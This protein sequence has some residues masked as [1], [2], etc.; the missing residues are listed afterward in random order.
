[1]SRALTPPLGAMP[2][3]DES[4]VLGRYR[5]LAKLGQGGMSEVLLASAQSARGVVSKLSV[6]KRLRPDLL[7]GVEGPASEGA[8]PHSFVTMFLEE[9]RITCRLNH[10]N[11]VHTYEV[12]EEGGR[13]CIV[14][15]YIDGES[16]HAIWRRLGRLGRPM[17]PTLAA[18][19]MS[20]ALAGLHYAHEL[21]DYDG[22]PL[23]VVHRDVSPHNVMVS[24]QGGVKLL[25]FGIAKASSSQIQT[26]VGVLKGKVHYMAPEQAQSQKVDRRADVFSAGVI[27]WELLTSRRLVQGETPVANWFSLLNDPFPKPSALLE[28]GLDPRLDAVVMR[29]LEKDPARRYPSALAMREALEEYVAAAGGGA[30]VERVGHFVGE[31][32]AEEREGRKRRLREFLRAPEDPLSGAIEAP[33][34]FAEPAPTDGTPSQTAMPLSPTV[35]PGNPSGAPPARAPQPGRRGTLALAAALASIALSGFFAYGRVSP[36]RMSEFGRAAPRFAAG[37]PIATASALLAPAPLSGAVAAPPLSGAVAALPLSGAVAAPPLSGETPRAAAGAAV[38][39][40]ASKPERPEGARRGGAR[41][42]RPALSTPRGAE[43]PAEASAA[44]GFLTLDTYPWSRVSE[45]GR[46]LGTTP[47]VR[48]PLSPGVHT[49]TLEN[50]AEGVKKTTTITIKSGENLSKRLA[51]Q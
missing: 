29:A 1:M 16:L 14:M 7:A 4:L 40:P 49:L 20:E 9:A 26:E 43:P 19:V 50:P 30:S 38:V 23:D 39:A 11:I 48:V 36:P 8:A 35:L 44:N 42:S 31:L 12:G 17:P 41:L 28:G 21:C 33:A 37:L 10:P 47:L 34:E 27:L 18:R 22:A 5:V 25:D 6:I 32:F 3:R 45:N 2:L 46:P 51:F 24:Y 15:E 13:L